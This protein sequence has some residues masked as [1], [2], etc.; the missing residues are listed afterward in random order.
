MAGICCVTSC[1]FDEKRGTKPKF[2]AQSRPAL[3]FSLELSSTRNQLIAQSEKLETIAHNLQGDNV[4]RQVEGF[5][6]SHF[7]ASGTRVAIEEEK[8]F[9]YFTVYG[10]IVPLHR[11]TA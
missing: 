4:A 1:E 7:A 9:M 10:K 3:Y 2:V 5:F 11:A 6:I 8:T